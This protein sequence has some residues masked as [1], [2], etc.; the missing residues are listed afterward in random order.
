MKEQRRLLKFYFLLV[1][2]KKGIKEL[3]NFFCFVIAMHE[4]AKKKKS[5]F[6]YVASCSQLN[7]FFHIRI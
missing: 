1:A 7:F 2:I 4:E 3:I 5:S 6:F